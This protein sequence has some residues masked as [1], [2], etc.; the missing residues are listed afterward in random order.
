MGDIHVHTSYGR[1]EWMT[2]RNAKMLPT[3]PDKP[4]PRVQR[5]ENRKILRTIPPDCVRS[6]RATNYYCNIA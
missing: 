1:T 6:T 3:A 5:V 4:N 2:A